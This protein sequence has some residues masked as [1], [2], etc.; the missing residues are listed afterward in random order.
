MS[1]KGAEEK[2][3]KHWGR[4]RKRDLGGKWIHEARGGTGFLLAGKGWGEHRSRLSSSANTPDRCSAPAARPSCELTR[5]MSRT[6]APPLPASLVLALCSWDGM[7]A[8]LICRQQNTMSSPACD[9]GAS[10]VRGG[11]HH[12][13]WAAPM[14]LTGYHTP[15][16]LTSI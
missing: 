1:R 13:E 7:S 3:R 10:G 6:P 11:P 2:D 15:L 8:N 4:Y 9:L 16:G 5:L 14:R 12:S